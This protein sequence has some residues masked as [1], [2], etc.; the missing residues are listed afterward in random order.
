MIMRGWLVAVCFAALVG[1]TVQPANS[2]NKETAEAQRS[3]AGLALVP[4]EIRSG[5][6]V[7]R[8]AVE[9]AETPDEQA[10]G[11][12]FRDK[13]GPDE[14]MIFPLRSPQVASFWMK[15]TLIPL[16][17]LFV[18]GD[19]TI[20]RIAVNTVPHSLDQVTS[21]EPVVAVLEV[22]GGRTVELGIKQNDR[23]VWQRH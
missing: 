19:G 17:M 9:V 7:H 4:L 22:A 3:K 23:V 18:R 16:D 10:R 5:G 1:C 13:L 6:R 14:G 21:G 11:L 12:M 8:F 2:L 20:A 15:N